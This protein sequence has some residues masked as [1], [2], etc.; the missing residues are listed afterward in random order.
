MR[1]GRRRLGGGGGGGGVA[2]A[3]RVGVCYNRA[4]CGLGPQQVDAAPMESDL[5]GSH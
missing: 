4:S 1:L 5:V 2:G 3:A